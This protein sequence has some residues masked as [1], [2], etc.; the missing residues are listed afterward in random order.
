MLPTRVQGAWGV[1]RF[2]SLLLGEAPRLHLYGPGGR[3]FMDAV[4]VPARVDDA[5]AWLLG[6]YPHLLRATH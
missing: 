2:L 5:H 4:D 3:G 6:R 1:Q